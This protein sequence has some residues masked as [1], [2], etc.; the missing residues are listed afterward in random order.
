MAVWLLAPDP[1]G[2]CCDCSQ[3]MLPCDSCSSGVSGACCFTIPT[4]DGDGGHATPYAN[5]ALAQSAL[6][7]RTVNCLLETY[8]G[9]P[10][11]TISASADNILTVN[12]TIGE[13]TPTS[14][15]SVFRYLY[16][17]YATGSTHIITS[18]LITSPVSVSSI[19]GAVILTDS[20]GCS[21]VT[22]GIS[23]GNVGQSTLST[24]LSL[25]IPAAGKYTMITVSEVKL[26]AGHPSQSCS[27]SASG[28]G[29]SFCTIRAAYVDPDDPTNTLYTKKAEC[30]TCQ[31]PLCSQTCFIDYNVST[32]TQAQH[33]IDEYSP[34]GCIARVSS[35]V[36][37]CNNI[38]DDCIGAVDCSSSEPEMDFSY[39]PTS[40]EGTIS[41]SANGACSSS[42]NSDCLIGF[43]TTGTTIASYSMNSSASSSESVDDTLCDIVFGPVSLHQNSSASANGT[44]T[45]IGC[46]R[47]FISI[48]AS[49]GSSAGILPIGASAGAAYD[50]SI[51]FDT[52][53]VY[54]T[55]RAFYDL[56]ST[57]M[58]SCS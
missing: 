40:I 28:L 33:L 34:Y 4:C 21:I 17:I 2:T 37:Q 11:T 16:G 57:G 58:L 10:P 5:L 46:S 47:Q 54:C 7:N 6:T 55:G 20:S 23:A 35:L 50:F 48:G 51:S 29:V 8:A 12:G 15:A 43:I 3:R 36:T 42:A 32:F 44:Y 53:V 45:F 26:T 1:A 18:G 27:F 13:S 41:L 38:T 24:S 25:S 14:Q 19:T 31:D 39:S 56:P 49:A 52:N 22:P 9:F 30:P